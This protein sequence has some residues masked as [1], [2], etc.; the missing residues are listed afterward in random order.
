MATDYVYDHPSAEPEC[1]QV[2]VLQVYMCVSLGSKPVREA[3]LLSTKS[4]SPNCG[5]EERRFLGVP[6]LGSSIQNLAYTKSGH[7]QHVQFT[8]AVG[9]DTAGPLCVHFRTTSGAIRNNQVVNDEPPSTALNHK[10]S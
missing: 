5:G 10:L 6:V 9:P 8:D 1:V 4:P 7:A 2:F 3:I